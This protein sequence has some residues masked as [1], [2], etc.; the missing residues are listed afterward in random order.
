MRL[1]YVERFLCPLPRIGT[2]PKKFRFGMRFR[3]S[4]SVRCCL[5]SSPTLSVPHPLRQRCSA[6][7]SQPHLIPVTQSTPTHVN[8]VSHLLAR[9]GVQMLH[10]ARGTHRGPGPTDSPR[11][12]IVWDCDSYATANRLPLLIICGS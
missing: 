8:Q 11:L 4:R 5:D 1:T 12:H 3:L 6:S 9:I 2:N 7:D 10:L